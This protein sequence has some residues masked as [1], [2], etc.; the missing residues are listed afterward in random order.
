MLLPLTDGFY[1]ARSIVASAQ[2]CVNLYGEKNP[3]SSP[4]P[5]T[6]YTRPGLTAL[7]AGSPFGAGRGLYTASNGTLYAM[8][9]AG[10][11]RVDSNWNFTGVGTVNVTGS[12]LTTPVSM[13]DNATTLVLVDG[14]TVGYTADLSTNAFATIT[15]PAWVGADFTDYIDTFLIFNQT[16]SVFFY[17]TLSNSLTFDPLYFAGK[18]GWPDNLVNLQ[19]VHREIWLHGQKTTEVWGDV[20]AAQFPFAPLGG[21]FI[22]RGCVAKYSCRNYDLFTFWLGQDKA[23][24]GLVFMGRAYNAYEISTPALTNEFSKYSTISDAVGMIYQQGAHAFYVLTFPSADKTWAYDLSTGLWSEWLSID[25]NGFEHRHRAGAMAFA[26]GVNVAQDWQNGRL[27]NMDLNNFTDNGQSIVYRRGF[28]HMVHLGKRVAYEKFVAD[29]Q[30]GTAA[31]GVT[32]SVSLRWSNDRGLTFG[33]PVMQ[34]LG[35]TGE[36]LLQPAWRRLGIGRDRVFE[37]FWSG[38]AFTALN[39]AFVDATP[40]VS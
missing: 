29:M 24:Q 14:T 39:G 30:T 7:N 31:A 11:Y 40:L 9:G 36:S 5:F 33:N 8:V 2:R 27:Y 32:P 16:S 25:S 4:F 28:P 18:A 10:L 35:Q 13:S 21:V 22:Q 3:K 1:T 37:L 34:T 19:V 15:D 20:G 17:S 38:Q 23:G 12:A 26:Y 6:W